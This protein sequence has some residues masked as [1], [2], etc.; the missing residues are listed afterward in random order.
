MDCGENLTNLGK[1]A[2]EFSIDPHTTTWL[3]FRKT[4]NYPSE[5]SC[6]STVA[7]VQHTS[8][9]AKY[10]GKEVGRK[11]NIYFRFCLEHHWAD[12]AWHKNVFQ[13]CFVAGKQLNISDSLG[14]LN[15]WS[16]KPHIRWGRGLEQIKWLFPLSCKL[17]NSLIESTG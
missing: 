3:V 11:A 10:R 4:S 16:F 12:V 15:I 7:A 2:S 5:Y 13:N 14:S 17:L 1:K 9:W 6:T 8:R